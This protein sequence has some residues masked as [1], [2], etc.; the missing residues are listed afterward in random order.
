MATLR[1]AI[2]A[3]VGPVPTGGSPPRSI[4]VRVVFASL[5][6]ALALWLATGQAASGPGESPDDSPRP[7]QLPSA[8]I[9]NAWAGVRVR[10]TPSMVGRTLGALKTREQVEILRGPIIAEG[11]SWFEISWYEGRLVGWLPASYLYFEAAEWQ[12][13]PQ[14]D[15]GA[16]LP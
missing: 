8:T 7:V 14:M 12:E 5:M 6:L 16:S 1:T 3:P 15:A 9:L 10:T 13:G 2:N 11:I 4:V